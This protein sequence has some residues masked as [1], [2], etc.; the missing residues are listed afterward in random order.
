MSIAYNDL[1]DEVMG[2]LQLDAVVDDTRFNFDDNVNAAQ[3]KLLNMLDQKYLTEAIKTVRGNLATD[4][5]FYQYPVDFYRFLKLWIDYS[6][7]ITDLNVGKRAHLVGDTDIDINNVNRPY[8]TTYP[9]VSLGVEGG[10]EVRPIP[11]ED[12]SNGWR[13]RYVYALAEIS[14]TQVCLL[15]SNLRNLLVIDTTRRCALVD[16][17]NPELAVKYDEMFKEEVT[18]FLPKKENRQSG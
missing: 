4:I 12:Q 18:A 9:Q 17:F 2:N 14:S 8:S 13:M 16:N 6:N 3:R 7:E 15:R 11:E 5:P 10:F 1:L